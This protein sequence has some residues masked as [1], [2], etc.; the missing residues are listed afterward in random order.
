MGGLGVGRPV[1]KFLKLVILAD[2]S[3]FFTYGA[4]LKTTAPVSLIKTPIYK[5][6]PKRGVSPQPKSK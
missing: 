4:Q 2:G 5:A 1:K 6:V 3:S